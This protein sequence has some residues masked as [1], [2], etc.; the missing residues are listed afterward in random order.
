MAGSRTMLFL[1]HRGQGG[2]WPWPPWSG[3]GVCLLDMSLDLGRGHPL[4]GSSGK[5]KADLC[6]QSAVGLTSSPSWLSEPHLFLKEFK[7]RQQHS[8]KRRNQDSG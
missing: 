5:V 1:S 6:L 3:S 8:L 7:G 4:P 2:H